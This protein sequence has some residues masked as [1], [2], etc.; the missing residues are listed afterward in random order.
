MIE[1]FLLLVMFSVGRSYSPRLPHPMLSGT[2]LA[3]AKT[4]PP[5][6]DTLPASVARETRERISATLTSS[7]A[8]MV[9][10][11]IMLAPAVPAI[12]R[13]SINSTN[14]GNGN[15]ATDPRTLQSDEVS[16]IIEEQ[17]LGIALE[18]KVYKQATRVVVK[19]VLATADAQ[20][21]SRVKPGFILVA[22]GNQN[23][24]G[25]SREQAADVVKRLV[26]VRPIELVFRDP[27]LFLAQ[28]NSSDPRYSALTVI[29]TSLRPVTRTS[30][31]QVYRVDRQVP[32]I[33]TDIAKTATKTPSPTA[34]VGDVLEISLRIT[35]V[36]ASIR[37]F[38]PTDNV[39]YVLGGGK[40]IEGI[41]FSS[42]PAD[43]SLAA[44]SGTEL[45]LEPIESIFPPSWDFGL[46][47]ARVGEERRLTVPEMFYPRRRS[48]KYGGC[49]Y[50]VK[51][52]SINGSTGV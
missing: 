7:G 6:Q 16:L 35:D 9:W 3:M 48:G 17:T 52:I 47:G 45:Q 11:S 32:P 49:V 26:S 10:A 21:A 41:E 29:S 51:I 22:I 14:A 37:S 25:L 19:S 43:T 44:A 4:P 28:L 36:A 40:P 31:E 33:E 42:D 2:R 20:V 30:S 1:R 34:Q 15:G 13:E 24:E 38:G 46:Q 12:A 18:D 27:S 50:D 39:F 23:L 5:H 8:L